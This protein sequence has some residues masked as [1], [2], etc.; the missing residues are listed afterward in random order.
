MLF[1]TAWRAVNASRGSAAAKASRGIFGLGTVLHASLLYP[2]CGPF[3]VAIWEYCRL[4][5]V[6]Y[7]A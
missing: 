1:N 7:F 3:R 4:S 5:D 2:G 6:A